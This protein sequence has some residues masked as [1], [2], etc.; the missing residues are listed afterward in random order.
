MKKLITI[1]NPNDPTPTAMSIRTHNPSEVHVLLVQHKEYSNTQK[2]AFSRF[3]SWISGSIRPDVFPKHM[4]LPRMDWNSLAEMGT[5]VIY[6]HL[7]GIPSFDF[8]TLGSHLVVDF[9]SGSKEMSVGLM[10]HFLETYPSNSKSDLVVTQ[11]TGSFVNIVTGS[12]NTPNAILSIRERVWLSSGK[13]ALIGEKGSAEIGERIKNWG[14][15]FAKPKKV[16]PQNTEQ[17][18]GHLGSPEDDFDFEEGYW[19]E[20]FAVHVMATWPDVLETRRQM[21][22]MPATWSEFVAAAMSKNDFSYDAIGYPPR[23]YTEWPYGYD[24]NGDRIKVK[25]QQKWRDWINEDQMLFF[26]KN[27]FSV[28]QLEYIWSFAFINDVDVVAIMKNGFWIFTECKHRGSFEHETSQRLLAIAS[29]VAPR[30][31]ICAVVQSHKH[32]MTHP[33]KGV[34]IIM[35]PDLKNPLMS[36][37]SSNPRK[38]ALYNHHSK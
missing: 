22:L 14:L 31:S 24:E 25:D 15:S 6:H 21:H 34:N 36:I 30:S 5:K 32:T 28:E 9:F 27:K 13:I 11:L 29:S 35:W 38:I 20:H 26:S 12:I 18:S 3:K 19:L 4:W 16:M 17:L 8:A 2:N 10:A 23:G 37:D 7:D 1:F 33:K